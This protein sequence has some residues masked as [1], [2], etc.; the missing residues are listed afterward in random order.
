MFKVLLLATVCVYL[1][2]AAPAADEKPEPYAFN[3]ESTDEAGTKIARQESGDASGKITGQY[4]YTDANGL[5][6]TVNYIA[7]DDGFRAEVQSNEPGLISSAPAAATYN[8]W[9]NHP[10]FILKLNDFETIWKIFSSDK[11]K[12][13]NQFTI[14]QVMHDWIKFD[15][16]NRLK[17]FEPLLKNGLS[18]DNFPQQFV[19]SY[20]FRSDIFKQL[21]L[22]FQKSIKDY[23]NNVNIKLKPLLVC[24]EK[25]DGE[26]EFYD[27]HHHSWHSSPVSIG[28]PNKQ[29]YF[30]LALIGSMLYAFGGQDDNKKATNQMW[31]RDLSDPSSQWTARADMKQ[32]RKGFAVSSSMTPSTL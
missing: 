3:F 5:T 30:Q 21:S 8:V 18:F 1:V 2:A 32:S 23:V 13:K 31:S 6:R 17:Y 27:P 24:V 16:V 10:S 4:S 22:E 26:V 7:D 28:L 29:Q 12:N 9:I 15:T 20:I 14:W 19:E 25:K 11:L